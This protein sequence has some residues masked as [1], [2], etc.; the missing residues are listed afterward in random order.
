MKKEKNKYIF[1]PD[2]KKERGRKFF[3]SL[4]IIL[5]LLVA[6]LFAVNFVMTRQVILEQRQI[7]VINIPDDL[8]HYSILH[9]SNLHGNELGEQQ[10]NI[11]NA[12]GKNRY[13][14][15][16][17][18]GDM[19][20]KDKDPK[21]VLDLLALMPADTPKFFIPG[22]SDGNFVDDK[23]HGSLSVYTD[24]A[25]ALQNA[26]VIL[27]DAPYAITRNKGTV[28]FVPEG[29]YSLDLDGMYEVYRKQLETLNGR[30]A[31][32]NADEAAR[33]RALEYELDR[34]ERIREAKKAMKADDIQIVLSHTPLDES[35]VYDMMSWASKDN[36]CSMRYAT[37]ILAGHYNGGQWRI[38]FLG[39]VY[40]P[41]LGWFPRDDKITGLSYMNGI[42]QYISPGLGNS[43]AYP[44]QPNRIFNTPTL[45]LLT[46]TQKPF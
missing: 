39:P 2:I 29:L 19:L 22:D 16:V 41:D 10:K 42:P 6:G 1:A 38:P 27:L 13:S 44:N 34:A 5:L 32:L 40:V 43:D 4:W 33:K 35:Y 12:L 11:R 14:C 24:W 9:I 3:R 20:G 26:G 45:T 30:A 28:W 21:P 15:V 36:I 46:L 18:T 37:L 23:A 31:S 8:D 17:M 7:V 25:L